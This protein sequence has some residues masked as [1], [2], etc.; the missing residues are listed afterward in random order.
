MTIVFIFA[1]LNPLVIPFALIYLFFAMIVFKKNFAFVYYRRFMEKEGAVYF[2]RI[3]RFTLDGLTTAQIVILIF[4]S[5]TDQQ[6]AYIALTAILLPITV[7]FKIL[8]TKLW[9]SQCRAI[10]DEEANAICGIASSSQAV[11]GSG[12]NKDYGEEGFGTGEAAPLDARASG[13]YPSLAAPP[14]TSSRLLKFWQHLHDSFHAN[15]ADQP[16][17][18]AARAAKG[19]PVKNPVMATAAFVAHRPV[20]AVRRAG[21][22]TKQ[23]GHAAKMHLN[24][25]RS[26]RADSTKD[27]QQQEEE[28]AKHSVTVE[29]RAKVGTI[30]DRRV[31]TNASLRYR[32]GSTR[33]GA[34]S[35]GIEAHGGLTRG[36]STRSRLNEAAVPE[37]P[38]LSGFEAVANHAPVPSEDAY[39]D[40]ED[41]EDSMVSL[42]RMP[43]T[44]RHVRRS[45]REASMASARRMR[46]QAYTEDGT[47]GTMTHTHSASF[48]QP[49]SP[50]L[51]GVPPHI[52]E[53]SFY[54][55]DTEEDV[56][57]GGNAKLAHQGEDQ[58]DDDFSDDSED[59]PLVRPHAKI[60][61]DDT[62]NNQARYNNPFY[63]CELDPFL[64]LPRDPLAPLNLCD[65]IEW[66]GPAIV[67]S[68]G[69]AGKVGEW[70]D[71]EATL[72]LE[73]GAEAG[74]ADDDRAT[75][76]SRIGEIAGDEEIVMGT[77]LAQR[78]EQEENASQAEQADPSA[79]LPKNVLDEYRKAIRRDA[80]AT[81]VDGVSRLSGGD[82]LRPAISNV[83]TSSIR[84]PKPEQR[85]QA[86][87]EFRRENPVPLTASPVEERKPLDLEAAATATA[88]APPVAAPPSPEAR[89]THF[90]P[91]P[92]RQRD[93][94]HISTA[95]VASHS[96]GST[97][98][99]GPS[100]PTHARYSSAG[101]PVT[102]QH[103]RRATNLS[104][105]SAGGAPSIRSTTTAGGTRTS[106]RVVTMR[107]ALQAEVL[108]EERRR[109]I[110]DRL[111]AKS[112]M[113][114]RMGSLSRGRRESSISHAGAGGEDLEAPAE[115][116][117]EVEEG[118][119]EFGNR[120]SPGQ[121][122]PSQSRR[123][124]NRSQGNATMTRSLSTA[125]SA[126]MSRHERAL[127]L[128]AAQRSQA[129]QGS[130]AT[131]GP[132]KPEAPK[133]RSSLLRG[134]SSASKRQ[135]TTSGPGAAVG[136]LYA[137][138]RQLNRKPSKLRDEISGADD[139]DD[140]Q[141]PAAGE[142]TVVSSHE[143]WTQRQQ[144]Q[145]AAVGGEQVEMMPLNSSAIRGLNT[146][147]SADAFADADESNI[148]PGRAM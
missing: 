131:L 129:Q 71:D 33:R 47:G 75:S 40:Y 120:R 96:A 36:A 21:V 142:A 81:D 49:L 80:A 103:Q 99:S 100:S 139:A 20:A 37:S 82:E 77:A 25:D 85:T 16:S 121:M 115:G 109:S 15:G 94:P 43:R 63:S 4:F 86:D 89:K 110:R 51:S 127:N 68:D 62:P 136:A 122:S 17:Y 124:G 29:K 53:A 6:K 39:A 133:R 90:A 35:N 107:Q 105:I 125:S 50:D 26:V 87:Q 78:L 54:Y 23:V 73:G 138:P 55:E 24:L 42:S 91:D 60:R 114:K 146:S 140:S 59:G 18:L 118:I 13:R 130:E 148:Q 104:V 19:Q 44:P 147:T 52:N 1:V 64:W 93:H 45:M 76:V 84:S 113:K 9:K 38:F 123:S 145:R 97:A 8:G 14:S 117:G 119:D 95:M 128:A 144:Q 32:N 141:D 2:I 3:F 132:S 46:S 10:E 7:G 5:V 67:S 65:T 111:S 57:M 72:A 41:G 74:D 30:T 12:S 135:S 126:I 31:P 101:N 69:G 92:E 28:A 143:A 88:A 66:H 56:G 58:E 79:S 22:E 27:L 134:A 61:W 102:P 98:T 11:M 112:S 108:E 83:S 116:E 70:D 48:A 34:S 106:S 137:Q